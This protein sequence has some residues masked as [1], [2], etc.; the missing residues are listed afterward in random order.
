[1]AQLQ[2]NIDAH[3]VSLSPELLAAVDAIHASAPNPG[4]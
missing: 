3:E 2:Q 4:Q 1:V